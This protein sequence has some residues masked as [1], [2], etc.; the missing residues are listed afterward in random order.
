MTSSLI[1]VLLVLTSCFCIWSQ[2]YLILL[3]K[4]HRGYIPHQFM[5]S[6]N[7]TVS[8]L[9]LFWSYII[10]KINFKRN[11]IYYLEYV[12]NFIIKIFRSRNSTLYKSF[13]SSSKLTE[14]EFP[15]K[16]KSPTCPGAISVGSGPWW[17]SLC[18]FPECKSNMNCFS[19]PGILKLKVK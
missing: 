19:F 3:P 6:R 16:N 14:K 15:L 2:L 8:F 5:W 1:Y 12:Q 7:Y 4:F 10:L 18:S 9:Q 13:R 11:R 17:N